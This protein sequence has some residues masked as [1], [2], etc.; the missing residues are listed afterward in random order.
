MRKMDIASVPDTGFG[1][2]PIVD[3]GPYEDGL[4]VRFFLPVISKE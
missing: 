1:T 4:V 3:M 2:Q